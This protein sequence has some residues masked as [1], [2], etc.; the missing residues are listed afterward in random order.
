MATLAEFRQA[1]DSPENLIEALSA[2]RQGVKA[3]ADS[4]GGLRCLAIAQ[5]IEAPDYQLAAMSHDAPGK[6]SIQVTHKN[7]PALYFRAY[8]ADLVRRV[9]SATDYNL[10]PSGREAKELLS[11]GAPAAQWSVELPPT[12]DYKPHRAF[13]TP[14]LS[15]PGLYVVVASARQDFGAR[16]NRIVSAD[17]LVGDL[18]L[19]TR[20]ETSVIEARV[21]TGESGEPVSG[22]EVTLYKFDWN[23]RHAPV[24]TKTSGA[25]GIARFEYASGR[26]GASYFL[27]ARKG[28][29]AALDA[30]YLS[31]Q[32]QPAPS[33]TTRS[34][35]YTDRSIY[36]P[37]QTIS[38]K[39]LVFHGRQDVGRFETAAGS[40]LT[41]SLLDGNAQV[42]ESKTSSTNS[43]G[44]AS[45]EF[46]IPAGRVLGEWRI[47]TSAEGSATVR[48]EEYKR[49]TFEVAW[50]DIEGTARLNR[51]VTLNGSARYYFGLPV[52]RGT[53]I[54]RVTRE[55]EFPWWWSWYRPARPAKSSRRAPRR[56]PR[57]GPS[58][59]R[60]RPPPTRGCRAARRRSSTGTRR[61]PTSPTRGAR[62]VRTR[63]PS[64]SGS[65]AWKPR[66][67]PKR[68]SFGRARRRSSRFH[69]TT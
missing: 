3:Y 27:L 8:P 65:W 36:R 15:G 22:A 24:E 56:S 54:W 18:V 6:R 47:S 35:V 68:R 25:D 11:S 64:A 5:A 16:A 32:R 9:E 28:R 63:S 40:P 55:P 14:P 39:A 2:A 49:P 44:T 10:L 45:G 52:T 67:G 38:W 21:L 12:P 43:F 31:L 50:K 13:V 53:A 48:V 46:R 60:S 26:E 51:P 30:N 37:G 69:A 57:T 58:R 59:S 4:P 20:L 1:N 66:R 7:V 42:V 23:R 62:P 33:D 34:L 17:I 61:R 41:V 29:D 19:V